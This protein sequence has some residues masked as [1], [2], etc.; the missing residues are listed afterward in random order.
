MEWFSSDQTGSLSMKSTR[1]LCAAATALGACSAG[2]PRSSNDADA[3]SAAPFEDFHLIEG[4]FSRGRGPDGNT[5]IYTAPDGLVVIDTGRHPGHSQLIL[6]YAKEKG[7]PIIAI[8]NTHWHLDHTTGNT[9][10]KATFPDAKVYATPAIEGAL[11]GFLA[12]GAERTEETLATN[13]ELTE[14]DRTQMRRGLNTIREPAALLP[15]V[16]VTASMTL[17]VNGRDLEL[18]VTDRATSESDIWIWDP[19]TKTAIVG[20]LVTFP[21]PFFDTGCVEGWINAFAAI[22]EKPYVRIAPGHGLAMTPPEFRQY[23]AAFKN[24]AT[25]AAEKTGA[26]CAEG[27]VSDAGTLLPPSERDAAVQFA[28]YYV[29]Q[30]LKSAAHQK[31]FCAAG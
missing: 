8:V 20:D 12:R 22:E 3:A 16:P 23:Q 21:A 4:G 17:P 11:R 30:I 7:L 29:D 6:D 10:I 5:E 18:Y 26:E 24:L 27:W 1:L 9:D 31:E 25:C 28:E 13:T 14:R 15:D 19:A 2:E